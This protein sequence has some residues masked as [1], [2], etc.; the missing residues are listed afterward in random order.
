MKFT[1]G[2]TVTWSS[3]AGGATVRKKGKIVDVVPAGARPDREQFPTLYVGVGI[4]FGRKH[5]SYVVE[6]VR[7]TNNPKHRPVIYWPIV[8]QLSLCPEEQT[9]KIMIE[10]ENPPKVGLAVVGLNLASAI[11]K[12]IPDAKFRF[13]QDGQEVPDMPIPLEPFFRPGESFIITIDSK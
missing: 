11:R 1:L 10:M 5:E 6:A 13:V 7:L 9:Q 12:V 3:Q 2:Q 8:S 4:G